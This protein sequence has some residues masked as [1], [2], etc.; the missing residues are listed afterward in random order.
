MP[1]AWMSIEPDAFYFCDNG[2]AARRFL[3]GIIADMV[4]HFGPVTVQEL[5]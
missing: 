1:D 2:G 3:G 4:N 5:E